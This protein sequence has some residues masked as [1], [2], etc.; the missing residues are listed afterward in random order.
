MTR[1]GLKLFKER[2]RVRQNVLTNSFGYKYLL[3]FV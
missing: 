3:D 1:V 2:L